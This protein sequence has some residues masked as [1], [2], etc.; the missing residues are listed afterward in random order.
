M[1]FSMLPGLA[2]AFRYI[3]IERPPHGSGGVLEAALD[4][5]V[6][7]NGMP[8]CVES[9][10]ALP[11]GWGIDLVWEATASHEL[12]GISPH[13]KVPFGSQSLGTIF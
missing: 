10:P 1:E 3:A 5:S 11:S 7:V 12:F 8:E 9:E 2:Q 13:T 4:A 6:V